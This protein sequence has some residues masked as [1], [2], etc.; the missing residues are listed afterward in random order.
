M[1]RAQARE[2]R[3]EIEARK[4]LPNGAAEKPKP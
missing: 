1:K 3:A 2:L 4:V